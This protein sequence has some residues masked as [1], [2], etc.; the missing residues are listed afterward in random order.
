MHGLSFPLSTVLVGLIGWS[1]TSMFSN[2]LSSVIGVSH[3]ALFLALRRP[4][5]RLYRMGLLFANFYRYVTLLDPFSSVDAYIQFAIYGTG[6]DSDDRLLFPSSFS[7]ARR[8]P[9]QSMDMKFQGYNLAVRIQHLTRSLPIYV[10][11]RLQ[12]SQGAEFKS[13]PHIVRTKAPLIL[14]QHH[15]PHLL[16]PKKSKARNKKGKKVSIICI[17]RVPQ[18]LTCESEGH[19]TLSLKCGC[20]AGGVNLKPYPT[21]VSNFSVALVYCLSISCNKNFC[22]SVSCY[23]QPFLV[24]TVHTESM[25]FLYMLFRGFKN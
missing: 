6:D 1:A 17:F 3:G 4:L 7:A 24:H 12:E 8:L 14:V 18:P 21:V 2:L 23:E 10:E 19:S 13:L 16:D 11:D 15:L 5:S 20:W 25:P 9:G 22:I